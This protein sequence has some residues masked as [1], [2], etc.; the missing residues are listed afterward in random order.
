MKSEKIIKRSLT[1]QQLEKAYGIPVGTLANL[2]YLK[3]GCKYHK[4]G[5]RILYFVE[6]IEAWLRKQPF[7]TMDSLLKEHKRG[8]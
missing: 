3:R 7:Q 6:D 4:V 2:R 1:P 8:K 5:R